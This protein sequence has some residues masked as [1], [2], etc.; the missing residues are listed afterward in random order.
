MVEELGYNCTGFFVKTDSDFFLVIDTDLDPFLMNEVVKIIPKDETVSFKG[1]S[2]G[3]KIGVKWEYVG[4][5]DPRIMPVFSIFFLQGGDNSNID[6][7]AMLKLEELGY[8]V[9]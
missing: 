4:D 2:T 8:T 9:E 7:S 1:L 3:D 5:S 6:K